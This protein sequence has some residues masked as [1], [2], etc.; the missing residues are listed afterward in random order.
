MMKTRYTLLVLVLSLSM[1]MAFGTVEAAPEPITMNDND[2][3]VGLDRPTVGWATTNDAGEITGYRGVNLGL[4]YSEKRYFNSLTMEEFN[5]YWGFGTTALI[6]PYIEVGGDYPFA[7]RDDGSFFSVG[8]AISAN[9]YWEEP[10]VVPIP[11]LS[12]SYHF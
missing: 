5:T 2:M 6:L 3:M 7:R 4:G 11:R 12:L 10:Y 8:G 1:V 9:V